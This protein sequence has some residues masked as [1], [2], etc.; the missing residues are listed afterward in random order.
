LAPQ[1]EKSSTIF[2]LSF[3]GTGKRLATKHFPL[4]SLE[5][6]QPLTEFAERFCQ[7][8]KMVSL[9]LGST[10]GKTWTKYSQHHLTR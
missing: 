8:I 7:A 9:N 6:N 3:W 2:T 10:Q 4:K 5:A 1:I